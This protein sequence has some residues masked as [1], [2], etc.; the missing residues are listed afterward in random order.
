MVIKPTPLHDGLALVLNPELL[1]T[2]HIDAN[3]ELE[4]SIHGNQL[5]VTPVAT[6][7]LDGAFLQA[8]DAVHTR[9]APAFRKLAE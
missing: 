2:L 9:F 1:A 6:D 5:I 7:K 3:T 4:V 8:M